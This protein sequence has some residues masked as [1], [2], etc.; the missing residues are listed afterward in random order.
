M[1]TFIR[2]I[3]AI[4]LLLFASGCATMGTSSSLSSSEQLY[5]DARQAQTDGNHSL[6]L[7]R[8][9]KL[10]VDYPLSSYTQLAPLEIA[11]AQYRLKNFD[12][13]ISNAEYFIENNPNHKNIDYAY[14]LK[15]LSLS[16]QS[17]DEQGNINQPISRKA[18]STF[19]YL[20]QHYPSSKYKDD[21][22]QRAAQLRNQL[23]Q[24]ELNTVKKALEKNNHDEAI[25][26]AKYIA[27]H[28]P[29]TPAAGDALEMVTQ[30]ATIHIQANKQQ[31][32]I[33]FSPP[34][35]P[36]SRERE[37]WV[38]QQKPEYYT[39][40]IAASS[41]RQPLVRLAKQHQLKD[42][43]TIYRQQQ[44][45]LSWYNLLYGS[46][47]NWANAVEAAELIKQQLGLK[48]VLIHQYKDL[49]TI[50]LAP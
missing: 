48:N 7:E 19:V 43:A 38:M 28:Y 24:Y 37:S 45:K 2:S 1:I 31:K 34:D 6:A 5:N 20:I 42:H 29:N 17:I 15:G 11:F 35:D 10:T 16:S 50:I 4:F 14:H 46:Y 12:Q 39:L 21:A 18:Y 26:R 41:Q 23:A 9:K 33:K 49:H 30:A 36:L 44:Y 27:E 22:N 3:P 8:L 32:F 13:A 25:N 40:Q 47:S